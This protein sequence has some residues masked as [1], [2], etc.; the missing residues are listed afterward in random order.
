MYSVAVCQPLFKVLMN[1]RMN[2]SMNIRR[3]SQPVPVSY[4]SF[5]NV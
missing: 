2:Q 5:Y 4:T 1:E 3:A